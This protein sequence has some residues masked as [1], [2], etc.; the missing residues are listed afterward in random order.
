MIPG[1]GGRIT[2]FRSVR[3]GQEF[4]LQSLRDPVSDPATI[5]FSEGHLGGFDECLPSVSS[6]GA[7]GSE[8]EV[9]DHGDLW[10]IPWSVRPEERG[11]LLEADAVSRPLKLSRL[12]TLSADTLTLN[13]ELRNT[14]SSPLTWLWCAH[15][16]LYAEAGDRILL[17]QETDK[18]TVEYAYHQ[19]FHR[20]KEIS[21]PLAC[22]RSGDQVDLSLLQ[23]EPGGSACKLFARSGS[24]GNVTLY[25]SRI[26]QA[27]AL[28]FEPAALPFVG[29]WINAGAWPE[30]NPDR[31][32]TVALEPATCNYDSLVE[33]NDHG[34]AGH[35]AGGASKQ[36][37]LSLQLLGAKGPC[38][39]ADVVL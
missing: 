19:M 16:L 21:W 18:V 13:Y 14:S 9:P 32:F 5:A 8:A 22:T 39:P 7:I 12:A 3:T 6:C 29:I 25:R 17:P 4:L 26:Q 36:W 35:L 15:P 2:S 28:H 23:H 31:R 11:F 38:A 37:A 20:R 30:Q 33:A 1:L 24:S 34:A 10:R 27:I